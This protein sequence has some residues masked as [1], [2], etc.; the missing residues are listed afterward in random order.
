MAMGLP[1][2]ASD[3]RLI[4]MFCFSH[5]NQTTLAK[6]CFKFSGFHAKHFSKQNLK[7]FSQQITLYILHLQKTYLH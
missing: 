3:E 2:T 7:Q 5:S 1:H 4:K 6:N